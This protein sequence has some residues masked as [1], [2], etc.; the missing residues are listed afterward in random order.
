MTTLEYIEEIESA[1]VDLVGGVKLHDL[2]ANTGLSEER[3]KEIIDL[4]EI[5]HKKYC[6]KHRLE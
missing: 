2:E 6:E 1:L 4:F 3:C 5:V